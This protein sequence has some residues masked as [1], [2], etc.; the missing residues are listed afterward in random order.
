[1]LVRRPLHLPSQLQQCDTMLGRHQL[2]H[3]PQ[4]EQCGSNAWVSVSQTSPS[5]AT[6]AV[7]QQCLGIAYPTFYSNQSS[8]VAM[9]GYRLP[10]LLPQLEQCGSNAWASLT[11]PSTA[12]RAVWLQCLG[13]TS[14]T[15]YRDYSSVAAMHGRRL[16]QLLPQLEQC[17]NNAWV[18]PTPP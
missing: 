7:W 6:R 18:S 9:L 16:R 12:T 17:G 14:S 11:S 8:V 5:T 4:L 10:H 2:H 13:V 1:M 3:L 15:S